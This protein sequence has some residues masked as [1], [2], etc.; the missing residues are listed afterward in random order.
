MRKAYLACVVLTAFC[1]A[2]AH[3]GRRGPANRN[4]QAPQ[5]P[6]TPAPAIINPAEAPSVNLTRFLSAHLAALADIS[7]AAQPASVAYRTDL[8]LLHAAFQVQGASATPDQ[9]ST[10]ESALRVCDILTAAVDERD[11]AAANLAS[12]QQ[13]P[14]AQDVKDVRVSTARARRG[15]G[16]ATRAN[17]AKEASK[18]SQPD[19]RTAFMNSAATNAW[20]T[21]LAQLRQQIDNAY[22]Q[23]LAIERQNS[24]PKAPQPPANPSPAVMSPSPS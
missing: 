14:G 6:P 21:R 8:T 7:A 16:N 3:A 18:N 20:T 22:A 13:V 23:E 17:N 2:T 24:A 11:K 12:S 4:Q 1:A 19:P 10:H 15:Y 5:S 9:K